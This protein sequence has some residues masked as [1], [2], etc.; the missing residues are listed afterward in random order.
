MENKEDTHAQTHINKRGG[1]DSLCT[2]ISYE[3]AVVW[4]EVR[5]VEG[6]SAP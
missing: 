6:H 2:P 3:E 5:Q 1:G 4:S